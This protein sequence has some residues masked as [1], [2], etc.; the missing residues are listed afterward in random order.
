MP[1]TWTDSNE[2]A[3]KTAH[4]LTA[5]EHDSTFGSQSRHLSDMADP[6]RNYFILLGGQDG[7]LNSANFADQVELWRDGDFVQ[8]PLRPE[9]VQRSFERVTL[10]TPN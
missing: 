8:V 6:D 9:T 3:L 1:S 10:L 7:W 5:E 4:N 2:T